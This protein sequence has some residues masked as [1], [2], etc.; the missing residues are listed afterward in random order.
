LLVDLEQKN[1]GGVFYYAPAF[2]RASALDR[3][4]DRKQIQANSRRAKPS[5]LAI[6]VDS[7]SHHFS[8]ESAVGGSTG[9]FSEEPEELR[10]DERPIEEVLR[11]E[12]DRSAA[13]PLGENLSRIE[14]WFLENRL[15][16]DHEFR[17]TV[18]LADRPDRHWPVRLD[19][20]A[21]WSAIHL[22]SS[23]FLLQEPVS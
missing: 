20:L 21:S 13:I 18:S 5:E 2:W 22:N 17:E 8:F 9:M 19:R 14:N 23:L 4:F 6:P 15:V 12:L 16:N 7:K 1:R 10:L 3:L 11:S